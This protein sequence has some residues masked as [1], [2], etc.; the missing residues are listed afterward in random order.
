MHLFIHPL[1]RQEDIDREK[2]AVHQEFSMHLNQDLR[3]VHRI[4]QLIAPKGHPLQRFGCGNASTL[5]Q[6]QAQDM[7][8]WFHQHYHPENMIAVIHTAETLEKAIKIFPKI[9]AQIPSK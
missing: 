9:F 6:V 5:A 2:H 7:H 3:R 8:Q 4:Q 1:F